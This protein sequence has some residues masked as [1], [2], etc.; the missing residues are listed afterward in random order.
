MDSVLKNLI[1]IGIV[2]SINEKNGTVR[3]VFD[4]K[5]NMV[6]DELPM[7]SCEYNMPKVKEQVLCLFLANG[8]QV[9]FCL[10]SFYSLVNMP[11]V[12]NKDIYY[13]R[14]DDGTWIQYNKET[15]ELNINAAGNVNITGNLNVNGNISATGLVMDEKGNSNHHTH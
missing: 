10:G 15:K 4:D 2:S 14:F 1:R 11:P 13:K 5:D 9:G 12:Q 3:V 6:S 7:L 8:L